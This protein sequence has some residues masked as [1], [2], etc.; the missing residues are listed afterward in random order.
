VIIDETEAEFQA[1]VTELAEANGWQ[2]M[3]IGR[4]GKYSP[5]GAKGTLGKGWPDLV[6]TKPKRLVFAEL[7]TMRGKPPTPEQ[8]L[9][10]AHLALTHAEVYTWRPSDWS[11]ILQ[12]LCS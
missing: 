1:R 6:L 7:K 5:N 10:M 3:H 12:V 11:L 9:V 8:Q 4:I 2:W